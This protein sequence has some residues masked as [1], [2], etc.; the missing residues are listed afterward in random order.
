MEAI[1]GGQLV[2]AKKPKDDSVAVLNDQQ[3][4]LTAVNRSSSLQAPIM[5]LS[6]RVSN[7]IK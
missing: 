5:L 1:G 7:L 6:G 4:S 2:P 3:Q